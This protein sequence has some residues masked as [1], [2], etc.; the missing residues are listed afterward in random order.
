MSECRS[1]IDDIYN[2]RCLPKA[3]KA[4]KVKELLENDRF[5]CR[6][7]KRQVRVTTGH[8]GVATAN[9]KI[10]TLG[11]RFW[12]KEIVEV[13]Y[14]KFFA[15]KKMRGYRDSKFHEKINGVFICLVSSAL[16]HCLK[17]WA[18]GELAEEMV[19]FK[20]ETAAGKRN[21]DVI[22]S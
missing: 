11:H 13:I 15:G 10:E 7:D 22:N 1:S 19:D 12:A 14:N 8:E 21:S 5:I 20:Y 4:R 6:E 16:R 2:F 9:A 3:E 18:M 17:H